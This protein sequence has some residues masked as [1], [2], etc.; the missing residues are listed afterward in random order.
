MQ[1]IVLL[2][3]KLPKENSK[4]SK[5]FDDESVYY[6]VICV[7]DNQLLN[8]ALEKPHIKRVW[9]IRTP[10]EANVL[11]QT[12]KSYIRSGKLYIFYGF[13]TVKTLERHLPRIKNGKVNVLLH[14]QDF[15][16]LGKN[17]VLCEDEKFEFVCVTD[18]AI[19]EPVFELKEELEVKEE[20]LEEE[21]E[22]EM[23]ITPEEVDDE[24]FIN[25]KAFMDVEK[26]EID[27][28]KPKIVNSVTKMDIE[29]IEVSVQHPI[30]GTSVPM[31][32]LDEE[33]VKIIEEEA[34]EQKRIEDS[35]PKKIV[36]NE[37][38]VIDEVPLT[39]NK[40]IFLAEPL[41][42][43]IV[44]E[45]IVVDEESVEEDEPLVEEEPLVQEPELVVEEPE[46]L[47]EEQQEPVVVIPVSCKIIPRNVHQTYKSYKEI[48]KLFKTCS[49]SIQRLYCDDTR[50]SPEECYDYHFYSDKDIELF[51]S[52][53]FLEFK[54]GVFDKLP[55]KIMK[56]DV[57]RYCLMKHTGGVYFDMDY[58]SFKKYPFEEVHIKGYEVV[59]PMNRTI[60]CG[61]DIDEVGN[62]VIASVE[63][64]P[65]WDHV[66]DTI[67]KDLHSNLLKYRSLVKT[68]KTKGA[69]QKFVLETTGPAFL[70][71][72]YKSFDDESKGTINLLNRDLF[73][74]K[75]ESRGKSREECIRV[76]KS[77]EK[78]YGFHHSSGVWKKS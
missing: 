26:V 54:R 10:T 77:D 42:E 15:E 57:F 72:V 3:T 21:E 65:F 6:H 32:H 59:L 13:H 16:E 31:L 73:H 46:P 50:L 33:D 38:T 34:A 56:I 60:E 55:I 74:P 7:K 45:D 78:V 70:W 37:Y 62:S 14:S 4:M 47:L 51:M 68:A 11:K 61:D 67:E 44:V 40:P 53:H 23:I 5:Y 2:Y 39:T 63:G 9:C 30:C 75:L 49:D 25:T 12:H 66:L 71:N 8:D 48:P 17:T 20:E 69:F 19:V 35:K 29:E 28:V 43:E 58:E 76:L 64:H 52:K 22:I 27:I 41:E 36:V 18:E 24:P 1:N